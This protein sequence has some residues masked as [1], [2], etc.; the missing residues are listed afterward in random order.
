MHKLR[1]LLQLILPLASRRYDRRFGTTSYE[2]LLICV[3]VV[4]LVFV[5]IMLYFSSEDIQGY[6]V[7]DLESITFG[8][9]DREVAKCDSIFCLIHGSQW[10]SVDFL[11]SMQTY[12]YPG[13]SMDIQGSDSKAHNAT[14][15]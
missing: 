12:A 2:I 15:E 13:K 5:L 7:S 1:L 4:G 8:S 10:I 6:R 9:G 11:G 3:E 14:P